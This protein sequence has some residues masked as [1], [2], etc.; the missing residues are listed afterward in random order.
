MKIRQGIFDLLY[1]GQ[2]QRH[3]VANRIFFTTSV[4]NAKGYR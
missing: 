2:L 3:V 4:T 1:N